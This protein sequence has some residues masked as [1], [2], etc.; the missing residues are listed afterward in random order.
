M[1]EV[2]FTVNPATGASVTISYKCRTVP[3]SNDTANVILRFPGMAGG[4]LQRG[5]TRYERVT[6]EGWLYESSVSLLT[7]EY[8]LLATAL[9]NLRGTTSDQLTIV[10]SDGSTKTLSYVAMVGTLQS[11][12]VA[13]YAGGYVREVSFTV[14]RLK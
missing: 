5:G 11:G 13:R 9:N 12:E 6:C 14:E 1:S 2:S 8:Q 4:I 3:M 10:Y 7:T